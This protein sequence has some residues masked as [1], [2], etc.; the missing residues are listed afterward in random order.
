MAD[1][2]DNRINELRRRH[3]A[4]LE[5]GTKGRMS[6]MREMHT[7]FARSEAALRARGTKL[8]ILRDPQ[9]TNWCPYFRRSVMLISCMVQSVN[10]TE[11]TCFGCAYPMEWAKK[12]AKL[13]EFDYRRSPEDWQPRQIGRY[14][15]TPRKDG[16]TTTTLQAVTVEPFAYQRVEEPNG[17]VYWFKRYLWGQVELD[18]AA[19]QDRSRPTRWWELGP[20][21]MAPPQSSL[22]ADERESKL[23]TA[24]KARHGLLMIGT[25][26]AKNKKKQP[27]KTESD[28]E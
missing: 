25:A 7:E 20:D 19:H 17:D 14:I 4:A 22:S 13:V 11:T 5:D 15:Q 2:T 16:G 27:R 9:S 6:L 1:E 3:V 8:Q 18:Y 12:G 10:I 28:D 23:Y 26:K 21:D 24:D